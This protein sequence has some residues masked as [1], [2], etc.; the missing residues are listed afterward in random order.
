M[1]GRCHPQ[2]VGEKLQT[3]VLTNSHKRYRSKWVVESSSATK[4][5]H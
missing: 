3:V 5:I 4:E 1:T 2:Q